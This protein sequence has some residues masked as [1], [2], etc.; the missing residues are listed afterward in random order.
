M[1]KPDMNLGNE[2]LEKAADKNP[3]PLPIDD[4]NKAL[5]KDVVTPTVSYLVQHGLAEGPARRRMGTLDSYAE[6]TITAKGLDHISED[7]GLTAQGK[8][9]TVRLEAQTI[10]DLVM[11]QVELSQA[12]KHEKTLIRRQLEAL[13]EEGL[14]HLTSQLV[15]LALQATPN[16]IQTL[17]TLL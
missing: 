7:G 6:I 10:R 16:A 12:P 3:Q 13:P 14:K 11:A 8:V 9:I 15:Q 2:L 4:Y 17:K 5:G 1:A